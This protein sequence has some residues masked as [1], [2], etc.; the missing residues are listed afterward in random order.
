[1]EQTFSFNTAHMLA[2]V[3][4]GISLRILIT[5]IPS[6]DQGT[7]VA[8]IMVSEMNDIS[9]EGLGLGLLLF[10]QYCGYYQR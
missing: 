6:A 8:P 4:L 3:V 5:E 7:S 10:S 9:E 1:M 2:K